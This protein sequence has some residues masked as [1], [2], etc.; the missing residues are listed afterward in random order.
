MEM[1]GGID[2]LEQRRLESALVRDQ[3]VNRPA[4]CQC[5]VYLQPAH[6]QHPSSGATI[7]SRTWNKASSLPEA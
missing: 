2:K 7:A 4:C 5:Q 6:P 1:F 3:G